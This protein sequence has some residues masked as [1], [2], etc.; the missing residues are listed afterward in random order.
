MHWEV[1]G[2]QISPSDES[3]PVENGVLRQLKPFPKTGSI[4]NTF[5]YY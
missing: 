1:S 5:K 3:H 2:S 4:L